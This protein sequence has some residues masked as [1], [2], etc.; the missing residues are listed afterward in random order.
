MNS[1]LMGLIGAV[2]GALA[3]GLLG[4]YVI[5]LARPSGPGAGVAQAYT[6]MFLGIF[7]AIL[8]LIAGV[9][10]SRMAAAGSGPVFFKGLG[11]T[12]AIVIAL[13][14]LGGIVVFL[15]LDREP[16]LD[17][18]LLDLEVEFRAPAGYQ[19]PDPADGSSPYLNLRGG[20]ETVGRYSLRSED[21]TLSDGRWGWRALVPL[22]TS[23]Q[24][25]EVS[26][27]LGTKAQAALDEPSAIAAFFPLHTNKPAQADF[28]WSNW[29]DAAW[30]TTQKT[31]ARDPGF[32]LRY[33][34]KFRE[35]DHLGQAYFSIG[36]TAR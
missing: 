35:R 31:P 28:D 32:N 26:V 16:R 36:A 3:A 22:E 6:V 29:I 4:S 20:S 10:Y 13:C 1:V 19:L 34:L 25:K 9:V 17:G 14:V 23:E 30:L 11:M 7:G 33:R 18:K 12:A 21:A 2:F 15:R 8:G 27:Y 24:N 5:L